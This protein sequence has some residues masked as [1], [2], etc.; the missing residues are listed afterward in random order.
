MGNPPE[1]IINEQTIWKRG[2]YMLL[3][4]FIQGV[5]KFVTFIVAVF[6][7]LT[8]LVTGSTNAKL[9]QLGRSLSTYS[10]Q[11][12]LFLTFNTEELPYPMGDWP[13]D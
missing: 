13:S 6:Q 2:L 10:Y 11:I 12:Y 4:A 1:K 5:A 8:V 9:L 7:F 3:F